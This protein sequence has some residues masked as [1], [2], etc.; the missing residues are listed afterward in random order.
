M[1]SMTPKAS[2][3]KPPTETRYSGRMVTTISEEMSVNRLVSPSRKTV[4]GTAAPPVRSRTSSR[5]WA[6]SR[7]VELE[8]WYTRTP[9]TRSVVESLHGP[10]CEL[11]RHLARR[12]DAE[13][14]TA[15][16]RHVEDR[17]P[18]HAAERRL[19]GDRH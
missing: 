11:A 13:N 2:G 9:R 12:R 17:L 14:A 16:E 3:V 19:I 15:R 18:E 10:G 6:R 4:R 8:T 7:A 1:P 5:R